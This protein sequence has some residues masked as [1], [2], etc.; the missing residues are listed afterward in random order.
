MN[1]TSSKPVVTIKNII[2]LLSAICLVIVF[3][4]TFLVSC[5]GKTID[6]SVMTAVGG[7]KSSYGEQFVEPHPMM[8]VCLLLPITI[9]V[10]TFMKKM[11]ETNTAIAST[12]CAAIDLGVWYVFKSSVKKAA[13]ENFCEYKTTGW[14]TLNTIALIL[15][16]GL[17]VLVVIKV[18]Q[19]E[20]DLIKLFG[21]GNAQETLSQ[22]SAAVNQMSN[23]VS[24][25]A[26]NVSVNVSKA[27]AHKGNVMGYCQKCGKPL[28]Y[29]NKFCTSCGFPVPE[30]LIQEF[31]A[32]K[33]RKE[34]EEAVRHEEEARKAAEALARKEAEE[35]AKEKMKADTQLE[36]SSETPEIAV[37]SK[38][39]F[40]SNCG[41]IL[42]KDDV[43]CE[44]CGTKVNK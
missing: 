16:I 42:S 26:E 5:S 32:E 12:I 29:D 1:E 17:S 30:A 6:V 41:Y 33:A 35:K 31:E 34:A 20:T 24:Q 44:K 39:V 18:V 40:C 28:I 19:L 4:P 2:R 43:F 10:C 36:T 25:L 14:F 22:M 23:S 15:I 7:L 37:E 21:G 8:L 38:P 13:E 3:C 9:L 11:T 27:M